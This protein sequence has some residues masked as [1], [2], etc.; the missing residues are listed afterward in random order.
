M[1]LICQSK[2]GLCLQGCAW[3]AQSRRKR[4]VKK[5]VAAGPAAGSAAPRYTTTPVVVTDESL[6]NSYSHVQPVVDGF[7]D[8]ILG[9]ELSMAKQLV[10]EYSDVF[11]WSEFDLGHCAALPH[12]TDTG[13]ARP[14][15]EQLRRHPI[16]H[17]DF[18]DNQVDQMLQAEVVEPCSSSWSSNVVSV[19][20]ADGTLRFCVNYRRLNDLTYKDSFPLPRIN[21]CLDALG[22]SVCFSTMDLRSGF[23]QVAIDPRDT[24]KTAFVTRKGQFRFRV[25]SFG[26]ANSPSIF[27]RLMTMILAGVN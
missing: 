26:L 24:D 10:Y 1:L 25:L 6:Q 7:S 12:R 21:T 23:W 19:R 18:I 20:K 14:F 8:T 11:S 2:R 15:K 27:Q 22:G 16:A 5:N 13:D 3:I 17:L 9:P 4:L